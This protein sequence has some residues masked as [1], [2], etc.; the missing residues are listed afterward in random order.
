MITRDEALRAL[1]AT[2]VRVVPVEGLGEVRVRSL[3]LSQ[4]MP[5]FQVSGVAGDLEIV[6]LSVV[7][8]DG[9]PLM[10]AEEWDR[11]AGANLLAWQALSNAVAEMSGA[12]GMTPGN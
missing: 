10:S 1:N 12:R 8:P 3:M 11:W 9:E 6:A 2:A 7:D 4:V 5:L